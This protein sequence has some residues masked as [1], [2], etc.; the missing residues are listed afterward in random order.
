MLRAFRAGIIRV[1]PVNER[2][3]KLV[4]L[5]REVFSIVT[6]TTDN[7]YLHLFFI[8]INYYFSFNFILKLT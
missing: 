3:K 5:K 6:I 1:D 2:E 7:Y 4:Y 8:I